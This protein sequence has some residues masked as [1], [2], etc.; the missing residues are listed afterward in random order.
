M[1]SKET[2]ELCK[3]INHDKYYIS[4]FEWKR[5]YSFEDD[6]IQMN[7]ILTFCKDINTAGEKLLKAKFY[8]VQSLK[9]DEIFNCIFEP[10]I[11]IE[12]MS[13]RGFEGVKYY[14]HEV[15]DEF[16][17]YCEKIEYWYKD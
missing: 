7:L 11:D 16:S 15:E 5:D 13:V 4:E 12:D 2:E 8:C 6:C 3:I 17:F 1:V 9:C 10:L 14:V